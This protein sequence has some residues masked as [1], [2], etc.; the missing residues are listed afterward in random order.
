[1]SF[2]IWGVG[3]F[4][5]IMHNNH[6]QL[7]KWVKLSFSWTA[8]HHPKCAAKTQKQRR[9]QQK[10]D[11]QTFWTVHVQW[12]SVILTTKD[13]HQKK[14]NKTESKTIS[15]QEKW[16]FLLYVDPHHQKEKKVEK[17]TTCRVLSLLCKEQTFCRSYHY[18]FLNISVLL[19]VI[20]KKKII[21]MKFFCYYHA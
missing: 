20:W 13:R 18:F 6:S 12:K 15:R 11:K 16:T 8:Y 7:L 14:E 4:W 9:K 10:P 19:K 3:N 21:G 2:S 17:N 5:L 1:M